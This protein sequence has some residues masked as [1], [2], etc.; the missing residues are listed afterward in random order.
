VGRF[1]DP[2]A[3]EYDARFYG[4]G[5]TFGTSSW[6][7]PT[8]HAVLALRSA[9]RLRPTPE[10]EARIAC[11]RK[12]L[13]DRRCSDAGWNYGNRR[14]RGFNLP[15]YAQ[16]TGLALLALAPSNDPRLHASIAR[17]RAFFQ[18]ECESRLARVMLAAG[19]RAHGES[20][21]YVPGELRNDTVL[22]ALETMLILGV[23][24]A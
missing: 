4:W 23:P 5:W 8:C 12:M 16:T 13:L 2:H 24:S 21:N 18:D 1:L 14:V 22:T 7:E 6:T 15:S 19:L 17:A 3:V 9:A 20:L 11:A 10:I